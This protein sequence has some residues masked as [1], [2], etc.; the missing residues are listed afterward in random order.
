MAKLYLPTIMRR[1]V[2]GQAT[3]TVPGQTVASVLDKLVADFPG[4]AA[5]L[6]DETGCLRAHI[7]VFVNCDDIRNLQGQET[8]VDDRDEVYVIP[9]MAGGQRLPFRLPA[10]GPGLPPRDPHAGPGRMRSQPRSRAGASAGHSP[11]H[12]PGA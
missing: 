11:K 10:A 1:N 7:N 6:L 4:V 12:Q 5:Q 8:A 3:L 9:A 2:G